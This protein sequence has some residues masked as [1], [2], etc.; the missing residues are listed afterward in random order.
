[1]NGAL[2]LV[3]GALVV[4]FELGLI[5]VAIFEGESLL[6]FFVVLIAIAGFAIW[7]R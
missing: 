2:R 5:Y 1:M 4:V 3:I 6:F 7:D